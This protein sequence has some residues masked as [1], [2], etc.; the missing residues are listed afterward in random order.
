MPEH[1]FSSPLSLVIMGCLREQAA[2]LSEYQ[3]LQMLRQRGDFFSGLSKDPQ[4]GL[5][6]RHFMLMNA[7]YELQKQLLGEQLYLSISALSIELL[8]LQQATTQALVEVAVDERLQAYYCDWQHFETTDQQ[9]VGDLLNSFW[10]RY[11]TNDKTTEALTVL[12]LS[13][14]ASWPMVRASYRRLAAEHHPD[15]GG[16]TMRFIAI[17]EAYEQL[18]RRYCDTGGRLV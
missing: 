12:E 5:F 14:D 13:V 9:A 7:L 16:E 6:Q 8:P 4:L 18:R 10:Q 17:R 1:H 15:R 11:I 3:L 2:P